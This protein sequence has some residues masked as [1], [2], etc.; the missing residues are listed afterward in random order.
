MVAES[1]L[2]GVEQH[3]G[4][5]KACDCMPSRFALSTAT[6]GAPA[7]RFQNDYGK[8]KHVDETGMDELPIGSITFPVRK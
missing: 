1:K 7:D 8:K 2:P 3:V 4:K 6:E 5:Q